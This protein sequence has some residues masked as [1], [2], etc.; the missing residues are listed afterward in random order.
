M[1]IIE[2]SCIPKRLSDAAGEDG[3]VV[4]TD[5]AAVIDGSTSKSSYR[6]SLFSSNGR[7][8]MKIVARY[9]RHAKADI[10]CRQFCAEVTKVVARHYHF[11]EKERMEAHPEDR[12]TCSAVLFSRK[13]RELWLIGDCQCLI[14]GELYDNP[15]PYEQ[16]LAEKRAQ[17]ILTSSF[18]K[19]HFLAHDSAREAILPE[20]LRYMRE[21]NK[22]YAVIDGFDI[23]EQCVRI[24][25]LSFQ[26][27]ELV[28]ASDGYPFLQPTLDQSE[29]RLKTLRQEDPCCVSMYK[30]TKGIMHDQE[31]YDDR[32]FLRIT[33]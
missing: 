7:K 23:P 8:A 29:E 12:L 18:P 2:S 13:R 21:Q 3:I 25:P 17:I 27:H 30:A 10:S 9:I 1:E 14:D 16:K 31:G 5:F 20:M 19:E 28:L 32:S 26:P 22:S 11:W 4:T 15:K 24:L 33:V 6:H